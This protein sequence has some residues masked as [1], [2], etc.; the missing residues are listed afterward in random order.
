MA[1]GTT[2][3]QRYEHTRAFETQ[4][5]LFDAV[6]A[7]LVASE[8]QG[9]S[10]ADKEAKAEM[11]ASCS[12]AKAGGNERPDKTSIRLWTSALPLQN[13]AGADMRSFMDPSGRE[14][15]DGPRYYKVLNEAVRKDRASP[16]LEQAMRICRTMN[17]FLSRV[18]TGATSSHSRTAAAAKPLKV[19]SGSQ[20][21][22]FCTYRG[23]DLPTE[24]AIRGF[25]TQG[26]VFRTRQFVASSG[27]VAT[28]KV[29]MRN[30]ANVE[31]LEPTL[32]TF[33][34]ALKN[35]NPNGLGQCN[36][37]HVNHIDGSRT[38]LTVDDED[39]YLLT[40]YSV[41]EVKEVTLS[42]NPSKAKPHKITLT[43][44]NDNKQRKPGILWGDLPLAPWG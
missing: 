5:E 39:E 3:F 9:V 19:P 13:N 16:A 10:K 4:A 12:M 18:Q 17:E 11:L 34:F 14:S 22:S 15:F 2:Y 31:G 23:G 21:P 43:V 30:A 1:S 26:K 37:L 40:P 35:V 27:S 29:Y 28:A 20:A 6:K 24:P 33:E 7:I 32:W 38:D 25:Y 36:C 42:P 41:L 8:I 44:H